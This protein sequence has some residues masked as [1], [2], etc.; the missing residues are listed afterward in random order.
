VNE[1]RG[2][3]PLSGA[4]EIAVREFTQRVSDWDHAEK[5]NSRNHSEAD[6]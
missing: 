5:H 4:E 2:I 6:H 1:L 3:F